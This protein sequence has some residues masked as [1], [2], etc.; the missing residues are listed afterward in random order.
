[1][2]RSEGSG[3]GSPGHSLAVRD[4]GGAGRDAGDPAGHLQDPR[5]DLL[6]AGA[7]PRR[8]GSQHSA[9]SAE[10]EGGP[11][12]SGAGTGKGDRASRR[13]EGRL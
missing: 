1:M 9:G 7:P 11:G 3:R 8:E 2:Q 5:G 6:E 13:R 12:G 4:R 10:M